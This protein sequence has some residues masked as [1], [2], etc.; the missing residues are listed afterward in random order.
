M[1]F[2]PNQPR[3]AGGKFGTTGNPPVTA[4]TGYVPIPPAIMAQAQA[5]IA[6]ATAKSKATAKLTPAQRAYLRQVTTARAIMKSDTAK[7]KAAASKAKTAKAKKAA[8]AKKVATAKARTAKLAAA[9]V[10]R[11]PAAASKG[12][13]AGRR[14][15]ARGKISAKA[16]A[17][18]Q[19]SHVSQEAAVRALL[20]RASVR[21]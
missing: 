14:A 17:V 6:A 18:T 19:T 7:A 3:Q 15:P 1:A 11:N 9:A 4:Q 5:Q 21:P 20:K 13:A 10:A 8:A 16:P 12:A 2:N